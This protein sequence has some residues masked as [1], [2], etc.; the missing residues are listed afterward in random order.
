MDVRTIAALAASLWLAAAAPQALAASGGKA[1][2]KDTP[3]ASEPKAAAR[4][5]KH[6]PDGKGVK[7]AG[8]RL[9]MADPDRKNP[10]G[11]RDVRHCLDLPTEKEVIRCTERK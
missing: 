7:A 10:H 1:A 6:A 2:T 8:P 9:Q 5:A 4:D 3:Q 11:D